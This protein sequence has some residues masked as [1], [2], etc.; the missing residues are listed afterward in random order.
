VI[1]QSLGH[2]RILRSLGKGG[3]GEVYAAEDTRLRREVALKV[4]PEAVASDPRRI[5]RFEREA[6]TVASLN[7][8]NIV[9]IYSV[10]EADGVRFLTME[11]VDGKELKELLPR[12]GLPVERIFS[13]AVPLADA[14]SVAH[15][16]GI[17]HRDLKPGN[18]MVTRDGRV[19]IL[20]FG[21]AKLHGQEFFLPGPDPVTQS[22]PQ[23]I[24]PLTRD[25]QI[26]GTVPYMSPEQ[27]KGRA[28]DERSDI[29]SLGIILYEMASGRP[30][31]TGESSGDIIS[32]ILRDQP[33][34][35]SEGRPELPHHL[36]RIISLCLA[37]EPDRRYQ[38]ARD[39]RNELEVLQREV[40][41]GLSR[42][43][44]LSGEIPVGTGRPAWRRTTIGA[45][46]LVLLILLATLGR[47]FFG[48]GAAADP[49]LGSIA[50]LPL[51]NLTGDPNQGYLGE[52][53][54]AGLITQLG[55]LS[56]LKVVGRS[57]TWRLSGQNLSAEE[58]GR[59]LS[60]EAVLEG[61]LQR[62]G[63][64]L[65]VDLNVTDVVSGEVVWSKKA[66]G[67]REDLFGLQREIA[68]DLAR[69]LSVSLSLKERRRLARNP[70]RDLRAYELYLQGQQFLEA[71]SPR[72]ARF[73]AEVFGQA[74]RLD[75][76]FALA[77][78]GLSEAHWKSYQ[79]DKEPESLR[80][81][82]ADAERALKIDSDLPSALVALARVY[83]STGRYAASIAELRPILE[84]H[85]R[86]DEAYGELAFSYAEAG[87]LESAERALE[88]AIALRTDDW[89]HRNSLG[90]FLLRQGRHAEAREAFEM[91][92]Q[93][94]PEAINWPY[95]NLAGLL[96][97]EGDFTGA[98]EAYERFGH[99]T[100]DARLASNIGTAYFFTGQLETAEP[101]Y[102][103]AVRLAPED[104][105]QHGNLG[106]VLARLGR[107]E[108]ARA[109][110]RTAHR[111]QS[112]ALA[113]FPEDNQL[114]LDG[115]FYAAKAEE[116]AQATLLTRELEQHLPRIADNLH[117]LAIIYAL[118][119]ERDA[120]I[121]A[122]G[123]AIELGFAAE[124]VRQEDEFQ[125]LM[126]DPDFQRLVGTAP[127]AA[128]AGN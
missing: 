89:R 33:Q 62:D 11:L 77:Y 72:S 80:R 63:T 6:Q 43:S 85:P 46:A 58:V 79:T 27:V 124:L 116:C 90:K 114:R 115:A 126:Q 71:E 51:A 2:Y 19:K 4:L 78:V 64:G 13:I 128:T 69:F 104:A 123:S 70:T 34:P 118:C 88:A 91:A 8:P 96:M 109:E 44:T 103:L 110:Y 66:L 20:D 93:L 56:G 28:A 119:D 47:F 9:T 57:K 23:D 94:A 53:I 65:Q 55:E 111:L 83:R 7:H 102:R 3:M 82:E 5:R 40:T 25:G 32:S 24:E 108:E 120:A 84:R 67:E 73:A 101:L 106:D 117:L 49:G 74:V 127:S 105:G 87:D 45:A 125:N 14:L 38:S 15:D 76:D 81:A 121:A 59:R 22:L 113:K 29:F 35:I 26:V 75:A 21:L 86:P 10:E 68:H 17:V 92:L 54:S 18:I 36:G 112:Q 16:N 99:E 12:N 1:G 42:P 39:L 97:L 95:E 52:G 50:V 31:F 30:V 60:V 37:K 107:A 100:S 122:L 41:E 48:P 61:S 98:I